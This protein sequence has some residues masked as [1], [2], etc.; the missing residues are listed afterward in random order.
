MCVCLLF[1]RSLIVPQ[2]PKEALG[3]T[4]GTSVSASVA[5][6]VAFDSVSAIVFGE[7]RLLR[8]GSFFLDFFSNIFN[9]SDVDYKIDTELHFLSR[10]AQRWERKHSWEPKLTLPPS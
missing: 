3:L 2:L 6:L 7:V 1:A 9:L 4:N 10:S 8:L 5:A